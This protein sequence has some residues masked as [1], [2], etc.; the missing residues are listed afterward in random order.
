M[1][2]VLIMI[3][4]CLAFL[5]FSCKG[6]PKILPEK[7]DHCVLNY[8]DFLEQNHFKTTLSPLQYTELKNFLLPLSRTDNTY[9]YQIFAKISIMLKNREIHNMTVYN[10]ENE[11]LLIKF[12]DN[13]FM[14][15]SK[16]SELKK[17]LSSCRQ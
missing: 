16:K 13:Y 3:S 5:L 7:I 17:L 2:T 14:S 4:V 6:E 11:Q 8:H 12:D 10:T 1:K 9:K 15:S